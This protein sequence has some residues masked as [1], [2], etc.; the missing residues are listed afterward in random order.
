[1]PLQIVRNDITKMNVDAVVNAANPALQMGGGVCG[2]I[3][4]AAG[5]LELQAECDRI[6]HCPPGEAV[7]TR[8][9]RL[10]AKHII[11]TVGPTWQ[12]GGQGEDDVLRSCYAASLALAQ[13]LRCASIAFPLISSG[14]YGY[15]KDRALRVAVSAIGEFLAEQEM[16]VFLVVY[17]RASFQI[18]EGL[19][20]SIEQFIDEHYVDE[21]ALHGLRR[22]LQAES[23]R[24][25]HMRPVAAVPQSMP[26]PAPRKRKLEDVVNQLEEPFAVSLLRMIDER[27]LTDVQVYKKANIDR[28]L[29]SKIRGAKGYNPGKRTAIALAIALELNWDE[30][31]DL[32]AKAGWA[33]SRSSKS[34]VIIEYF[35]AEGVYDVHQINEALFAFDQELLGE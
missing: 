2:A 23:L 12:G 11:H 22:R 14:I 4:A 31:I 34:D 21:H 29:F 16:Q 24:S 8:G 5:A 7:A 15:P 32:L 27:G 19:F 33:M 1:M 10:Q 26:A 20:S 17:D 3:F 25:E 35:I 6:G 28:K 30:T 9:W 18:G 13:R